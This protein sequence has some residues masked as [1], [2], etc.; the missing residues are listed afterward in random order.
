MMKRLTKH[1]SSNVILSLILAGVFL[2]LLAG[3][4]YGSNLLEFF[5]LKLDTANTG[6]S[7]EV[8]TQIAR[9]TFKVIS[10]DSTPSNV[11]LAH[12]LP[13]QNDIW[14]VDFGADGQ[15]Q[16]DVKTGKPIF[17]ISEKAFRTMV[18]NANNKSFISEDQA[19]AVALDYTSKMSLSLDGALS[20]SELVR[21]KGGIEGANVWD[22]KWQR[23]LQG[24]RFKD[25]WW[26]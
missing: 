19:K 9:K 25:D 23:V 20:S 14:Q 8:A 18:A 13:H 21:N 7:K 1:M 3:F 11:K 17:V 22:L 10:P 15:V 6:I 2:L 16:V 26:L 5:Q 4:S 24:Y 12:S